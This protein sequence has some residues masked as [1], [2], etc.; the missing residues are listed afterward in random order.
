MGR[1]EG[2]VEAYLTA[3]V[4]ERRGFTRKVVYQGRTGSPDRWCLF[5]LG[6]ILIVETKARDKPLKPDQLTECKLLRSLGCWVA[7]VDS[8]EHV[9]L[10]LSSF[11]SD[12]LRKF[13]EKFPL[14]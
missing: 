7:K 14:A 5:P 10:V 12:T 13:N 9:D 6:R 1:R 2:P 8:R 11:F 4:A 3:Q